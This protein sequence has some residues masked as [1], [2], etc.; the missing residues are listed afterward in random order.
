MKLRVT[1]A[2]LA[3]ATLLQA[4]VP[5]IAG[6]VAGGVTTALD[7]RSYNEQIRDTEI[8]HRFNRSFPAAL[9]TRTNVSATAFNR[10]VLLTG[11]AIDEAARTEVEAVARAVPNVREVYNEIT[12]GYPNSLRIRTNDA[13]ITSNV[14]TLLF[15]AKNLSGH[16]LKVVTESNTVYLMG[17][18]TEPEA[19]AATDIA[20]RAQGVQKVVS[21]I[22]IIPADEAKRRTLETTQPPEQHN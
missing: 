18:V 1:L 11:Q 16:H 6:G 9:E 15:D 22:E 20:R 10:W 5:L 19:R 7:R 2:A 17:L 12:I 14:K 3:G 21:L 8:E 13:L 4:C